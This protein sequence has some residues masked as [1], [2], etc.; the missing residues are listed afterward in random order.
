MKWEHVVANLSIP[1]K[2]AGLWTLALPYVAPS[3]LVKIMAT[4]S[5]TY[6]NGGTCGPEGAHQPAGTV[7]MANSLAPDA[8]VGSLIAKVGGGSSDKSGTIFGIGSHGILSAPADKAGAL[9]L[10]INDEITGFADNAGTMTVQVF[11]AEP[12]PA[13]QAK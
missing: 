6:T 4:G 7:T 13:A 8:L 2:P 1:A 10:G 5:W 3:S 12:A 11:I 9:Y